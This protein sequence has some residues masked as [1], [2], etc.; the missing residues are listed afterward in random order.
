MT[1]IDFTTCEAFEFGMKALDDAFV[2]RAHLFGTRLVQKMRETRNARLLDIL[3]QFQVAIHAQERS[4]VNDPAELNCVLLALRRAVEMNK[5]S[6]Y[7]KALARF[8][9]LLRSFGFRSVAF[10]PNKAALQRAFQQCELLATSM[11]YRTGALSKQEADPYLREELEELVLEWK[12]K[13][14]LY[15]AKQK[16][17]LTPVDKRTLKHLAR[18][19]HFAD[20][21]T[22]CKELREAMFKLLIRDGM[23]VS[24]CVKYPAAVE[25]LRESHLTSR[26]GGLHS[27]NGVNKPKMRILEDVKGKGLC[28]RHP[29]S[30]E[31][32][33]V[34]GRGVESALWVFKEKN[35]RPGDWEMFH[36]GIRHWSQNDYKV[37]MEELDWYRRHLPPCDRISFDELKRLYPEST[38][39]EGDRVWCFSSTRQHLK[40]NIEGTHGYFVLYE[41]GEDGSYCVYPFGLYAKDWPE[42]VPAM[43][44]FIGNTVP[45]VIAYPDPNYYYSHRQRAMIPTVIGK[46]DSEKLAEMQAKLRDLVRDE[47]LVFQLGGKNC[48]PE[49]EKLVLGNDSSL[50][51]MPLEKFAIPLFLKPVIYPFNYSPEFLKPY[52]MRLIIFLIGGTRSLHGM[53]LYTSQLVKELR[54]FY[55][56]RLHELIESGRQNGY[57]HWGH[58]RDLALTEKE[59]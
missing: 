38:L 20:R 44:A 11:H 34:L 51:K 36:D 33:P 7:E 12:Q 21:L 15:T 17:E 2:P 19:P 5:E 28:V 31:F 3:K 26:C 48:V 45:A 18:Y 35:V 13:Q 8:Q 47:K 58:N 30:G 57:F 56:G 41:P 53:S 10:A 22:E 16:A 32:F 43:F 49:A 14:K 1:S 54:M 6:L 37:P 27:F 59:V 9:S 46:G 25:K 50:T 23:R 42:S 29:E 52:M 39:E 4:G 55:P 40:R 24:H